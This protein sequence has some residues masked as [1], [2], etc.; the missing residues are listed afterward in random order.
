[1]EKAECGQSEGFSTTAKWNA[2]K[3]YIYAP[4]RVVLLV[5]VGID[6]VDEI[7]MGADTRRVDPR[8]GSVN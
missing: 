5:S 6:R 1:M 4:R 7:D 8:P 3:F 2:L